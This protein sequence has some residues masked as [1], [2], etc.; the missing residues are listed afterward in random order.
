[1]GHFPEKYQLDISYDEAEM[2]RDAVFK[3][4]GG[5]IESFNEPRNAALRD[6]WIR[7]GSLIS[8]ERGMRNWAADCA[9]W[10]CD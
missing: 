10:G 6:L 3:A 9:E 2:L 5:D 8:A 1:M 7:I 4:T